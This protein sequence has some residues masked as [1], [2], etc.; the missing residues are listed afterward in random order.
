MMNEA[1]LLEGMQAKKFRDMKLARGRREQILTAHNEVDPVIDII[2]Q[3][4]VLVRG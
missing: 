3:R 4:S 1:H 2:G